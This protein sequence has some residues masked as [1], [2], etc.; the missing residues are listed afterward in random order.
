M[1]ILMISLI[2]ILLLTLACTKEKIIPD[3]R[4]DPFTDKTNNTSDTPDPEPA[5]N[6]IQGLHKNIFL[7]RCANPTCHDGSFEPDYR[8]VQSTWATLVNQKVIKNDSN[9]SYT[10][11]VVPGQPLAS[12]LIE[13]LTTEDGI[14]GRMPLYAA[15][16]EDQDMQHII[17]WINN[18]AKDPE[19]KSYPV[20]NLPPEVLGFLAYNQNGGR[21]DSIKTAGFAS[22]FIIPAGNFVEMRFYLTDD[23]TPVQ[24]LTNNKVKFS[25]DKNDFSSPIAELNVSWF[26]GNWTRLY[27]QDSLFENGRT[28][29]FRYYVQDPNHSSP[30]EYPSNGTVWYIKEIYSF[31]VI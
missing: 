18:G 28:V 30:S 3:G 17:E 24:Q 16:L 22:A 8:T 31:V 12:W 20:P 11:R 4:K 25:Y 6:T 13:R 19:G 10:Y 23:I 2:S 14:L 9:F 21:I 15:P 29:Y 7:P 26:F 5:P 27:F 1:R